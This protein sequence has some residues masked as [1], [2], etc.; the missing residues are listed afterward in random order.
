M[1]RFCTAALLIWGT[2]AF[3][4]A[5][6]D[7][8]KIVEAVEQQTMGRD[9]SLKAVFE[10]YPPSGAKQQKR[11]EVLERNTDGVHR[12]L[13]RFLSP[14]EWAGLTL[15]AITG[16]GVFKKQWIYTPATNRARPMGERDQAESFAGT[17]FT[18]EDLQPAP[19]A[20]F[21]YKLLSSSEVI[22]GHAAYKLE[23]RQKNGTT[24]QYAYSYY[25]IAQ[26]VPCI[27][28][29]EMYSA[30]GQRLRTLKASQ[31]KKVSGVWGARRLEMRTMAT[32][33]RTVLT[34]EEAKFDRGLASSLFT[35]EA[36]EHA[37]ETSAK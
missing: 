30:Q 8:S 4:Q 17:D 36:L 3:A 21:T 14:P 15:L 13:V 18:Y 28:F 25:W 22:E 11:V 32:N 9:L 37:S 31:L 2:A 12:V 20:A 5:Q 10:V 26:D 7:P 6:N 33:S 19:A 24:S 34:I 35:P 29:K 1:N 23:G 16:D 27:L